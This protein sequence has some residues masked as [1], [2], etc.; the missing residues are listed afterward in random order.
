VLGWWQGAQRLKTLLAP[1]G[2]AIDDLGAWVATGVQ[3]TDLVPL[4]GGQPLDWTP[5]P[6]R[7]LFLDRSRHGRPQLV[8]LTDAGGGG[9]DTVAGGGV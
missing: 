2:A 1:P 8:I 7:A 6:G 4:L 9:P 5:T 3:G